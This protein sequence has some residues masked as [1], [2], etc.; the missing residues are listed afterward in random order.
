MGKVVIAHADADSDLGRTIAAALGSAGLDAVTAAGAAGLKADKDRLDG[1]ARVVL[2]WS[3]RAAGEPVLRREAAV[4]AAR[5]ALAVVRVDGH[6]PPPSLRAPISV[7]LSRA[8]ADAG[9][10]Q[11]ARQL[12]Q[13]AG[14]TH[15]GAARKASSMNPATLTPTDGREGNTWKGSLLIALIVAGLAYGALYVAN[16]GDPV[17]A[18]QGFLKA[19]AG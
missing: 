17:P 3:R 6:A 4:A 18:V 9:L 2:V 5:G 15:A 1:A 13:S 16:G 12:S 8:H 7:A 10:H 11:L 14:A 19:F